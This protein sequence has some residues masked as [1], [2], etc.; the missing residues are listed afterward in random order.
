MENIHRNGQTADRRRR[1]G[2]MSNTY[3]D[4]MNRLRLALA[5]FDPE[6]SSEILEDFETHFVRSM[7]NGKSE[8]EI[9]RELG[10]IEDV[11]QELNE[12]FHA[13]SPDVP[14]VT[15]SFASDNTSQQLFPV[16]KLCVQLLNASVQILSGESE[17][18]RYDYDRND[19]DERFVMYTEGNIFYLKEKPRS[20]FRFFGSGR[21]GGCFSLTLPP[22]VQELEVAS[23][24]GQ[25]RL[26]SLEAGIFALRS[27]NGT[28]LLNRVYGTLCE[29]HCVNG[30]ISLSGCRFDTMTA[31]SANGSIETD[32]SFASVSL[33]STNGSLMFHGKS[34]K[35]LQCKTVNGKIQI[36][37]TKPEHGASLSLS[38]T[39]GS[40][41]ADFNQSQISGRK[42]LRTSYGSGALSVNA[43]TVNGGIHLQEI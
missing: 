42:N 3:R 21:S 28:L 6:F 24:N 16:E 37:Y 32:G 23:T 13:T 8:A 22:T 10:S 17:N 29:T 33:S 20:L 12:E 5:D 1:N 2:T 14:K 34:E 27:T 25:I 36:H 9:C 31:S 11:I 41:R 19:F 4:Y 15:S 26:D 35:T 39:C 30:K 7:E 43:R 40:I 38:T 18:V